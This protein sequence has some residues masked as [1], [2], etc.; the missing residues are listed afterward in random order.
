MIETFL[1]G[2]SV[3]AVPVTMRKVSDDYL[4]VTTIVLDDRPLANRD[5][6]VRRYDSRTKTTPAGMDPGQVCD[7]CLVMKGLSPT[8]RKTP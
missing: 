2:R 1:S 6:H 8:R 5:R 4:A 3:L 7:V